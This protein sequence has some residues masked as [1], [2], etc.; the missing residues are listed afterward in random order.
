M[1]SKTSA[2]RAMFPSFFRATRGRAFL[3]WSLK[4]FK[5]PSKQGAPRS[6]KTASCGVVGGPDPA[7]ALE[8]RHALC[9]TRRR[10]RGT[11]LVRVVHP[12]A[13]N[14]KL[15][16]FG[17]VETV[18]GRSCALNQHVRAAVMRTH[19]SE[20][21][22]IEIL[23]GSHTELQI[24][25]PMMSDPKLWAPDYTKFRTSDSRVSGSFISG[26]LI[27]RART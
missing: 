4:S 24:G 21:K 14:V 22:R 1:R 9:L 7:V 19:V 12:P 20:K 16:T 3:R 27:P 8:L 25:C 5:L 26:A 15:G 17:S 11:K 13:T 2:P 10:P 18:A 6:T 23:G